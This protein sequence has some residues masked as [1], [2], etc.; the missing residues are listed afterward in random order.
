MA[1]R[2][3]IDRV[4][5][6][7]ISSLERVERLRSFFRRHVQFSG[8]IPV[9]MKRNLSSEAADRCVLAQKREGSTVTV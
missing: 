8:K 6:D 9:E 3:D 2:F 7:E 5:K 1:I 4:I